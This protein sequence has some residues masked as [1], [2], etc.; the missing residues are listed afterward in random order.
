M[1]NRSFFF[2]FIDMLKN[3]GLESAAMVSNPADLREPGEKLK[4]HAR[5]SPRALPTPAAAAYCRTLDAD[6]SIANDVLRTQHTRICGRCPAALTGQ[7]GVT[8]VNAAA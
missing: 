8:A 5:W 3:R 6:A 7:E 1:K 2:L 4:T